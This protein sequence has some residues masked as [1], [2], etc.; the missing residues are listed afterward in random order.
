[1]F[2]FKVVPDNGDEFVIKAGTRDVLV[3]EKTNKGKSYAQLLRDPNLTDYYKLSHIAAKRQGLFTGSL[4]DWEDQHELD[5]SFDDEAADEEPDPTQ[6]GPSP[7][8]SSN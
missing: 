5:L 6:S 8:H 3:W 1:M 4:K 2:T 7:D